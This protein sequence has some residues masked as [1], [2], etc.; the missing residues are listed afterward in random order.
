M[1]GLSNKFI[2][3]VDIHDE[4]SF[5]EV[6]RKYENLILQSFNRKDKKFNKKVIVEESHP[7]E[8]KGSGKKRGGKG[9]RK[10]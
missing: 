9:R 8:K 2:D 7:K 6:P 4:F 10:Y 5:F 1:T 3:K